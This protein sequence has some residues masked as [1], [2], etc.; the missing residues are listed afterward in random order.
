MGGDIVGLFVPETLGILLCG[1][2]RTHVGG[3]G[4]ERKLG[5]TRVL[6]IHFI[7]VFFSEALR[8]DR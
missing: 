6:I 7:Y 3:E 8:I 1:E 4:G 5:D 2:R